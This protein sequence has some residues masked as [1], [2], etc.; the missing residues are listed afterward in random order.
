MACLAD[1]VDGTVANVLTALFQLANVLPVVRTIA[2]SINFTHLQPNFGED[3]YQAEG[4]PD[5]TVPGLH[6][7]EFFPPHDHNQITFGHAIMPI[8]INSR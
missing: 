6:S 5:K 7:Q 3:L 2:E 8:C 1:M 4:T